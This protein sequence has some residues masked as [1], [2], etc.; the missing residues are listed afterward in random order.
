[1]KI[2][3]FAE[4]LNAALDKEGFPPKQR[5]RIQRLA[6]LM[7][8]THRGASKWLSGETCPPA[9]KIASIADKLN[10]REDWLCTGQDEMVDA[11][12]LQH[13]Q[14]IPPKTKVPVYRLEDLNMPERKPLQWI[15]CNI[16]FV[17]KYLFAFKLDTEAM[18]PRFPKGSII[19]CDEKKAPRDGD[20][21][22]LNFD[23]Y[24]LPI[25]RQLFISGDTYHLFA[26]N[27]KFD[28]LVTSTLDP[29]IGIMIQAIISLI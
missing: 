9:K 8:L 21:I 6:E 2:S 19:I 24:P 29:V 1:M 4:R 7:G 27:P 26:H 5:G 23:T 22:L 11:E 14:V 10:I 15:D 25:F 3:G 28:K 16:P 13:S 12:K 17:S 18:S 20:F